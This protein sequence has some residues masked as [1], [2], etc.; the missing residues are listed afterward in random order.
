MGQRIRYRTYGQTGGGS[1]VCERRAIG[2]VGD[3]DRAA[4]SKTG[5]GKAGGC[6]V[7][8]EGLGRRA[9]AHV[10]YLVQTGGKTPATITKQV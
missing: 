4:R 10:E 5:V 1:I 3:M 2:A 9:L 8:E 7:S 6:K